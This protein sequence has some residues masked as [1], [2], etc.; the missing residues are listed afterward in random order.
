MYFHET[1]HRFDK[2]K[3]ANSLQTKSPMCKE[4]IW[5]TIKQMKNDVFVTNIWNPHFLKNE[6]KL[7]FPIFVT[8]NP[9]KGY[10]RIY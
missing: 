4:K 7:V 3:G 10:G 6:L 9:Q 8:G 1:N 2:K 5:V